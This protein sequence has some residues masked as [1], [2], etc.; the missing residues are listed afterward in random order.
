MNENRDEI[1]HKHD[2]NPSVFVPPVSSE[3]LPLSTAIAEASGL[4]RELISV[5]GRETE[6]LLGVEGGVPAG[7]VETKADLTA[8]YACALENL[9]ALL[10]TP[11]TE[12]ALVEWRALDA[13]L[14]AAARNNAAAL[15]AAREA[16]GANLDVLNHLIEIDPERI[17]FR[18]RR[19]GILVSQGR[20]EEA[21]RDYLAVLRKE[22]SHFGA[23]NDFGNLLL[24]TGYHSAARTAYLQAVKVH[25]ELP[26]G[27]VNL[28]N[29]LLSQT[30]YA[31][32]KE[33]YQTALSLDPTLAEAHRGLSYVLAGLGD[34][35]GAAA[36]R[37][38][39][40]RDHAV[41]TWPHRGPGTPLPL[42]L[43]AS[44]MGGNIP[45]RHILDE[46]T[47]Q[48]AVIFTEYFDPAMP[49]PPHR[50]IINTI[51]DAD[52]CRSGLDAAEALVARSAAPVINPPT[53]V[54]PTGR[55]DNARRLGALPGVITPRLALLPRAALM[56]PAARDLVADHGIGFPLL[57]RSPGF[58]TGQHFV[59]VETLGD[60]APAA[61]VLPGRDLLAM[62]GLDARNRQGDSHKYRVMFVD[63]AL[64]P[65][66]LAIS[67]HWKVH[68][69]SAD[70]ADQPEHR[71][72]EAAFLGNMA[73]VL[74]A[75]AMAALDSI[76]RAL[77]LDYGGMDFALSPDGD[78]L[79]FEANATMVVYPPGPDEKWA[80]RRAATMRILEAVRTMIAGRVP[81]VT[82]HSCESGLKSATAP[83][84]PGAPIVL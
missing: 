75:K 62:Q 69:F 36:H 39:G 54:R 23:L 24:D 32:A 27:H 11:E 66:H 64:Y 21:H 77:G 76:R 61:E 43:L 38:P 10:G 52:L 22:P 63:G 49:L 55:L 20:D 13:G 19:A 14:M 26:A 60:L 57:L 29:L 16:T 40:F 68:Y 51:G 73:A 28:A 71:A 78:I 31:A 15:T 82:E 9:R 58:H 56:T 44:A 12:S 5:L 35:A 45:L 17:E 30:H 7:L 1:G 74:G 79:L 4:A 18:Y 41:L 48:S 72:Q 83:I 59:R 84:E 37:E 46:R 2:Q 65:L 70:M 42:I 53:M 25:P 47:V 6:T 50:L 81:I 33:H 67:K 8:A 34:E 80:Y 3:P